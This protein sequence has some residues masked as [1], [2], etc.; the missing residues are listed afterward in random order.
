MDDVYIRFS[1]LAG[2]CHCLSLSLSL[3][4]SISL[5]L[6]L[7]IS[8]S[9]YLSISLS[10]YLY[11][12]LCLSISITLLLRGSDLAYA[13]HLE[14]LIRIFALVGCLEPLVEL[15]RQVRLV[16]FP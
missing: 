8:I 10:I 1:L 9:L 3:Y 15:V 11:L 14:D 12:S 5:Y 4:L 16:A 2:V 6:Y 7:S 13:Q